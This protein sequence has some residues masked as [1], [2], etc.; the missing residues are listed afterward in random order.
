MQINIK[1]VN[2]P[3]PG[4]SGKYGSIVGQDGTKIMVPADM[5]GMFRQGMAVDV[6]TKEQTWGETPVI[7]ATGGPGGGSTGAVQGQGYSPSVHG[8]PNRDSGQR[9]N[10]GFT[11]RVYQGGGGVP[12]GGNLGADQGR[13]IFV[14]GTVGRAMGSGKFA[15]SELPVL[16]Q[17]ACEAYDK[18]LSAPP[19][20][21][22]Q[23]VQPEPPFNDDIS[24]V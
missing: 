22:G 11:P 14:T 3:R 7:V 4:G 1:F 12:A 2:F 5:L 21:P 9:A 20:P 16:T 10:T 23:P 24:D 18:V 6:P 17:A 15:A 8:T 13:Q 19:K